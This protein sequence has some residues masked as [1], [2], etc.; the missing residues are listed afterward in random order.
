MRHRPPY[1]DCEAAVWT[2]HWW[3]SHSLSLELSAPWNVAWQALLHPVPKWKRIIAVQWLSPVWLFATHGM[4]HA[5]LPSPSLSPGVCSNSCPL[6]QW[7]YLTISSSVRGWKEGIHVLELAYICM[8][9]VYLLK[10][11][12]MDKGRKFLFESLD[13]V[14]I[15]PDL[16]PSSIC[17]R[18][19]LARCEAERGKLKNCWFKV[20]DGK[21]I[22]PS[23][24]DICEHTPIESHHNQAE[25]AEAHCLTTELRLCRVLANEALRVKEPREPVDSQIFLP[26][27]GSPWLPCFFLPPMPWGSFCLIAAS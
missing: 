8:Q 10:G 27:G 9:F 16:F 24:W 25:G 3:W 18:D 1:G 7:C 4:K 6:S 23:S 20:H 13:N 15:P 21:G 17:S 19:S 5:R 22:A 12:D 26:R 11:S 14:K 2:L